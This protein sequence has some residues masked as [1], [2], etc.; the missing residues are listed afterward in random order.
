MLDY[1][2]A[3]VCKEAKT[4]PG[5]L[6]NRLGMTILPAFIVEHVMFSANVISKFISK[7]PVTVFQDSVVIKYNAS[8]SIS[9][10]KSI[11]QSAVKFT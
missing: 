3:K 2:V 8:S 4:V 9:I 10:K 1:A 11:L 5:S 6:K 7:L